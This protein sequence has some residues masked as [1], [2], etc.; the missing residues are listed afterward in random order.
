M[1]YQ[2]KRILERYRRKKKQAEIERGRGDKENL[3]PDKAVG[4]PT[5]LE[6]MSAIHVSDADHEA[7]VW[8]FLFE[9]PL[10]DGLMSSNSCEHRTVK[11]LRHL[12]SESKP[13]HVLARTP[14]RNF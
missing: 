14:L 4:T 3:Q 10:P 12:F 8:S 1:F 6:S 11:S 7:P 2:G 13:P 5:K 9:S